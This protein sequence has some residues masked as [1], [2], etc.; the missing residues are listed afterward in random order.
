[1]TWAATTIRNVAAGMVL[2]AVLLLAGISPASAHGTDHT[3]G[4]RASVRVDTTSVAASSNLPIPENRCGGLMC[5]SV[6]QCSMCGATVTDHVSLA[7]VLIPELATYVGQVS[8]AVTD[9]RGSPALPPPRQD[10]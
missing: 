9:A 7:L 10:P 6:G 5:C 3:S 2:L 1:M 8:A 4:A